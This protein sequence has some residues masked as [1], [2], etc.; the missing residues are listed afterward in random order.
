MRAEGAIDL[1]PV[2]DL[3]DKMGGKVK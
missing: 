2:C 3:A 1:T